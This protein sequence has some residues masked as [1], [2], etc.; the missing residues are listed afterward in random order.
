[1][2]DMELV[3]MIKDL[4]LDQIHDWEAIQILWILYKNMSWRADLFA[5][6]GFDEEPPDLIVDDLMEDG[7]CV[8]KYYD[9]DQEEYWEK[10]ALWLKNV[11]F[12]REG[13]D[14]KI[15][16]TTVWNYGDEGGPGV[17]IALMDDYNQRLVHAD[18]F[19]TNKME[20]KNFVETITSGLGIEKAEKV[21]Y[22][23]TF[24]M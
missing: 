15:H 11:V 19:E 5:V 23:Y 2:D 17:A 14:L 22:L 10:L 12:N 18:I 7:S 9:L 13:L 24:V 21:Y 16:S 20:G 4:K 3:Q 6:Q 1:M 8:V